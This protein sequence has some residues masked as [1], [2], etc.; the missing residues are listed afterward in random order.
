MLPGCMEVWSPRGLESSVAMGS[1]GSAGALDARSRRAT[2]RHGG[3]EVWR[4]ATGERCGEIEA[5]KSE[6]T[7]QAGRRG[8]M[9]VWGSIALGADC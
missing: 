8:R 7:L 5:W 2:W 3:L 9:E 1:I 6:G 4:G